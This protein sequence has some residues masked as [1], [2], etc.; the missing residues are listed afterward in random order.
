MGKTN[1]QNI[2]QQTRA[3]L[4]RPHFIDEKGS[5]ARQEPESGTIS[6]S[7]PAVNGNAGTSD[8]VGV[9]HKAARRL[10]DK[11]PP[12][13]LPASRRSQRPFWPSTLVKAKTKPNSMTS[14]KRTKKSSLPCPMKGTFGRRYLT[15]MLT[16]RAASYTA[17]MAGVVTSLIEVRLSLV[18]AYSLLNRNGGVRLN[19]RTGAATVHKIHD[20]I[21][22]KEDSPA[23]VHKI[24]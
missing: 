21:K 12:T 17:S 3:V 1:K 10:L 24:I 14:G 22:S 6:S 5:G 19:R 9:R 8:A 23:L 7:N 4:R 20:L 13:R 16:R 11:P 15:S 18:K 2:I